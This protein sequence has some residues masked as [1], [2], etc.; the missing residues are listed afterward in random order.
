VGEKVEM[1]EDGKRQVVGHL[2]D[3]AAIGQTYK[4][5]DWN[6]YVIRCEGNKVRNG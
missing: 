5:S 2:G 4:K 3:R 6:D 1:G